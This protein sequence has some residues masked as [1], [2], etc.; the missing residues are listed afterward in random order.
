MHYTT[1]LCQYVFGLYLNGCSM[2]EICEGCRITFGDACATDNKDVDEI[3]DFMLQ[4][5]YQL[6]I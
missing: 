3:I 2:D 5:N 1:E 6:I 4:V